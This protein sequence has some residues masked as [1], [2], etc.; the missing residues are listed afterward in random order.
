[1]TSSGSWLPSAIASRCS[2]TSSRAVCRVEAALAHAEEEG[3][4]AKG[5]WLRSVGGD[6]FDCDYEN[7]WFSCDE[8]TINGGAYSPVSGKRSRRR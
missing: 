5:H 8:C 6:D 7:A 4:V 3:G 2:T 1:M